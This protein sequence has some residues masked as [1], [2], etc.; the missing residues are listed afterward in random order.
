MRLLTKNYVLKVPCNEH[1]Y[2]LFLDLKNAFDS[3]DHI[4]SLTKLY[5]LN[6]SPILFNIYINELI[7]ILDKNVFQILVYPDD[8]E[9]IYKNRKDLE[10]A[11]E[12]ND[13]WANNNII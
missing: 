3:I 12:I 5:K 13:I 8:I 4:I 10:N 9:I 6:L 2:L 11:M 1:K 7:D